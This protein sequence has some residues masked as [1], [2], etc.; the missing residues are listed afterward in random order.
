MSA[1]Q[2]AW[3]RVGAHFSSYILDGAGEHHL[4]TARERFTNFHVT[5][6][7]IL[8]FEHKMLQKLTS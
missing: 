5:V 1:L 2:W 8:E 4:V 6:T 7:N 3:T